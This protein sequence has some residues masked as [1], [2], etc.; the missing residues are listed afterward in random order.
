MKWNSKYNNATELSGQSSVASVNGLF[1]FRN[2]KPKNDAPH[3]MEK[4]GDTP[5]WLEDTFWTWL[6][7]RNSGKER[8]FGTNKENVVGEGK[9]PPAK[10]HVYKSR[11]VMYSSASKGAE[12]LKKRGSWFIWRNQMDLL[13]RIPQRWD[14]RGVGCKPGDDSQ[15]SHQEMIRETAKLHG[16]P[17][18]DK[19]VTEGSRLN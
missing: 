6:T 9:P 16:A 12:D 3:C 4:D 13:L 19:I 17:L 11:L 2:F 5:W 10:L 7:H 1:A 18:S 8:A 15:Q 14:R